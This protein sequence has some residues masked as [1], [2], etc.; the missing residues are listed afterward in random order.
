MGVWADCLKGVDLCRVQLG[1]SFVLPPGFAEY[2]HRKAK[3]RL[4]FAVQKLRGI[5]SADARPSGQFSE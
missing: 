2:V 3:R 4:T 5:G 1:N